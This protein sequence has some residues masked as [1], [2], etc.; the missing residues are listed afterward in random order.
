MATRRNRS[1]GEL[2]RDYQQKIKQL[3]AQRAEQIKQITETDEQLKAY[4]EKLR[5]VRTLITAPEGSLPQ[6]EPKRR[7]RAPARELTYRVL[8]KRLG[9][10]LTGAQIKTLIRK[11]TNHRLS[12]QTVNVHLRQLEKE[13]KIRRQRAPAGSGGAHYVYAAV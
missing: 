6:P 10:W 13:G 5:W 3:D 1:L 4:E 9:S 11:D 8:H 7:R 12:R 2:E